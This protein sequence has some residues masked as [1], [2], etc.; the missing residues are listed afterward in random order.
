MRPA[1]LR[2]R[3]ATSRSKFARTGSNATI[4]RAGAIGQVLRGGNRHEADVGPHVVQP[5]T[6][7]VAQRTEHVSIDALVHAF[8]VRLGLGAAPR[9]EE[10][11]GAIGHPHGTDR[12]DAEPGDRGCQAAPDTDLRCDSPEVAARSPRMC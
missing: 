10:H 4:G 3:D 7:R 2:A 12:V 11:C 5:W 8:P 6:V 9:V 1:S